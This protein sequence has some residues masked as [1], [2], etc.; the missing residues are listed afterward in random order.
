MIGLSQYRKLMKEYSKDQNLSQSADHAG[1]DRKTARKYVR[2]G[3]GPDDE[4]AHQARSWRTREDPFKEVW[5]VDVLPILQANPHIKAKF[6][7]QE[8]QRTHEGKFEDAQLRT[9][10]RRVSAWREN[11]PEVK[12]PLREIFFA[13]ERL[14]GQEM[15]LDWTDGKT[16]EVMIGG[17]PYKHKLCHVVLPYSNWECVSVCFSESFISL[18]HGLQKALYEAGGCPEVLQID[19][20]STATHWF[21][22]GSRKRV[23]NKRFID[24]LDHFGMEP[25]TINIGKAHENGDVESSHHHLRMFLD[26]ELTF[27]GHRDFVSVEVYQE[28]LDAAIV[29]R[30]GQEKRSRKLDQE[31]I[32]FRTLPPNRLPEF[33]ELVSKVNKNGVVRAGNHAYSIPEVSVGEEVR[34]HLFETRVELYWKG[35]L[36]VT[37]SRMIGNKGV[38][39]NWRHLLPDLLRKP[40][41]FASY[42][43]RERFFPSKIWREAYTDLSKHQSPKRQ[44]REYLLLLELAMKYGEQRLESLIEE[45]MKEG[46]LSLEAIQF[47]LGELSP[48]KEQEVIA[49]KEEEEIRE[50]LKSYDHLIEGNRGEQGKDAA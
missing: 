38:T 13:Q 39:V 9:F 23:F 4:R 48:P 16:L 24:L 20:S 2:L 47:E 21:E 27:R 1:V 42:V 40:G 29:R 18:R 49:K 32:C 14:P 7:F 34:V 30:N 31:K 37:H 6:L 41:A 43:H 10:Q 44:S 25:R 35:E 12:L 45:R 50:G 17:L 22:K 8:L 3:H 5:E 46:T 28:F 36:K 33:D 19:N 15:Q 26:A 11:A